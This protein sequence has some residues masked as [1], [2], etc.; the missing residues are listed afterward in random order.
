MDFWKLRS[1]T[2]TGKMLV[3]KAVLLP[4]LLH[5]AV[6]FPFNVWWCK[7]IERLMAIFLWGSK[8]EKVRREE[9]K[10]VWR[11]G[12]LGFLDI[13]GFLN[14]HFWLSAFKIFV[15]GGRTA[16]LMRYHAERILVKFGWC[17]RDLLRPTAQIIPFYYLKLKSFYDNAQLEELG[18]ERMVKS[19]LVRWLRRAELVCPIYNFPSP[20]SEVIW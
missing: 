3:I 2:L 12:G 13:Q 19:R 6:V 10:K 9:I 18:E 15:G 20:V 1:L 14:M 7:K 4:L 11:N 16:R 8:M 5:Y 17:G